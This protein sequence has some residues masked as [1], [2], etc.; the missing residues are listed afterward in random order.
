MT[1]ELRLRRPGIL[2]A[3]AQRDLAAAAVN[4]RER[5][6]AFAQW[7]MPRY[8]LSRH[9]EVVAAEL[10]AVDRGENDRLI[11][12]MPPR[13]GKSELVSVRFPAWY[14]ARHPERHFIT[15][16]YGGD[17][18]SGFG[19]KARNV[20]GLERTQEI[21]PGVQLAQ[22]SKAANLWHTNHG[23]QFLAVGIGGGITGHGAHV[24]NIDDPIKTREE[25]E[26]FVYRDK[27][28]SW[29][30]AEAY[31]R[32]EPEGAIILTLTRWHEDDLAGRLLRAEGGDTWRVVRLPALAETGDPLGRE[33]GDALWPERYP[34]DALER[35]FAVIGS[36]EAAAL[37]QQRPAPEEGVIFKWWPRYNEAPTPHKE[38]LL[39]IDT[40]YTER[41]GADST[42]VA[43]WVIGP[44]NK[45]RWF[46][47]ESWQAETP[48]AERN[49]KAYFEGLKAYFPSTPIRPLVRKKVAIDR[50][51]AQHLRVLGVPVITVDMPGG[52][53]EVYAKLVAPEFEGERALI[54]HASP[55]L[56]AWRQQHLEFPNGL[57]DDY[58]ETT[59]LA[60]YYH[61]R[62]GPRFKPGGQPV[63]V[64]NWS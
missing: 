63:N 41:G 59:N 55:N 45:A 30:L 58:V 46:N 26:S 34:K 57:H 51:M 2:D 12:E 25:A 62:G 61:T 20:M 37:Y 14:M 13:H 33:V 64:Y 15:A 31:T 56:E 29:F 32:L 54:P 50:V 9:L 6:L 43:A 18:A 49:L 8:Q 3:D 4:A 42:A 40:A 48:Q 5:L 21:F 38:V 11:I 47:A 7:T 39:G 28:W 16:S 24:L 22:D 23:G 52:D 17:L 27:V 19:R 1:L 10:E 35:I 60:L 44:D 36:R 53:K